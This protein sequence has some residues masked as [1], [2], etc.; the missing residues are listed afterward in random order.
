MF[1]H[2]VRRIVHQD[3]Q[4]PKG[5]HSLLHKLLAV[6]RMRQVCLEEMDTPSILLDLRLRMLR[7]V[8][9]GGQIRNSDLRTLHGEQDGY[10]APDARVAAGDE[11]LLASELA[12]CF[13]DLVAVVFAGEMDLLG[14]GLHVPLQA[15]VL[16]LSDWY[17][18]SCRTGLVSLW[19]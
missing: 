15:G 4:S 9:L 13:V 1:L 17:F 11:R 10:S 16:L 12:G 8:L 2:L 14:L 19:S 6:I 5:L 18:V 7:I 3:V